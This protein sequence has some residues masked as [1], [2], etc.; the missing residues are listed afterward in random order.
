[1]LSAR[2]QL[3]VINAYR[4]VGTYRGAA[5]MC[6]VDPKTV[7]R[8]ITSDGVRAERASEPANYELVRALVAAKVDSTKCKITA[9]R[10]LPAAVAAG[11]EGS[12]RN[13]RRL[14]AQEKKAW[15][16]RGL[17]SGSAVLRS[18]RRVSTWSSTGACSVGCTCSARCSRS[19]GSGS[20]GSPTTNV[21]TPRW[22]C[23]RSASR[24]LVGSRRSCS[25]TGWGA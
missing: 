5:E 22:G 14:V 3:N 16:G 18:G 8:I 24:P 15:R 19:R 4:E 1:M 10:L 23:W 6:G 7:K 2:D 25:R 20:S 11:Y 9:K 17:R 12:D 21:P 13:F